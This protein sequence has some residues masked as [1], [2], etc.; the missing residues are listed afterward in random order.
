MPLIFG[1]NVGDKISSLLASLFIKI[2]VKKVVLVKHISRF[3]NIIPL[4]LFILIIKKQLSSVNISNYD[5]KIQL[6]KKEGNTKIK[7]NNN[8][9]K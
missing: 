3:S 8:K 7:E 9:I 1:V 4:I 6:M 2:C 5:Y